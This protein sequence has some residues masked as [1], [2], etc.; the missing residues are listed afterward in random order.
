MSY[1]AL[2]R[3]WRPKKFAELVGQEHVRRALVNALETGRVHH[4]FLFTGTRGV[5]KTTIARIFAKCLNCDTGVRR[6]RAV[7][8]GAARRSTAGAS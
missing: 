8:A 1:T 5:G 6:S 3:K 2:A 4:A 7:S